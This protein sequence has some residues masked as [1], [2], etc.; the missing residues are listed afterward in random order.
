M[1]FILDNKFT[2]N[3]LARN[4]LSNLCCLLFTPLPRQSVQPKKATLTSLNLNFPNYIMKVNS[5]NYF[6]CLAILS[7][8]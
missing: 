4:C 2:F 6:T 8:V 1:I 7:I 5:M 3:E